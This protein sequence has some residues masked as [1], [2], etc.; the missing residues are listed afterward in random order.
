MSQNLLGDAD[1][2]LKSLL[3]EIELMRHEELESRIREENEKE[4]YDHDKLMRLNEW[5]NKDSQK[6][7]EETWG[8]GGKR[9]GTNILE[10]RKRKG[11]KS[12]KIEAW[13][14]TDEFNDFTTRT[15]QDRNY[16]D[17]SSYRKPWKLRSFEKELILSSIMN[18]SYDG[19]NDDSGSQRAKLNYKSVSS[20]TLLLSQMPTNQVFTFS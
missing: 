2:R 14:E 16:F 18:L 5:K 11:L 19:G 1:D 9:I 3:R 13:S 20:S 8:D 12:R 17:L 4:K 7:G 10:R 15:V 6:I